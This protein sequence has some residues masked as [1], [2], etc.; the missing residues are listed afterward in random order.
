MYSVNCK[1][2]HRLLTCLYYVSGTC[3]SREPCR[4]PVNYA[5]SMQF[6]HTV[7]ESREI[8]TIC[9]HY[10]LR[11]RCLTSGRERH[12]IPVN[13]A[14]FA[15]FTLILHELCKFH[16]LHTKIHPYVI[17]FQISARRQR[18][19]ENWSESTRFRSI[20]PSIMRIT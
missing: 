16:T 3:H 20:R 10:T 19:Q 14:K 1:N 6:T 17:N 9:S 7:H 18:T 11:F 2:S 4:I 5:N 13:Q 8:R 12:E 15:Q